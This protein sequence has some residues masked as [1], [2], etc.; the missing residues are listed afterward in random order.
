M[1]MGRRI[2]LLM[3]I[4]IGTE[5]LTRKGTVTKMTANN[6]ASAKLENVGSG[7]NVCYFLERVGCFLF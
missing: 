1:G 5:M 3:I 4:R 6:G 2:T 7:E